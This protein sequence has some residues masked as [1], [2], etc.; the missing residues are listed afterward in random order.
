MAAAQSLV[1]FG[2]TNPISTTVFA[3]ALQS[4][5]VAEQFGFIAAPNFYSQPLT[6]FALAASAPHQPKLNSPQK[7]LYEE[8]AHFESESPESVNLASDASGQ[9]S[10]ETTVRIEF[11]WGIR[12]KLTF[13][14]INC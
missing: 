6:I 2:L 5:Q 7:G 3:A 13:I 1:T 4:Q 12:K 14:K 8:S 11:I 10:E 9:L